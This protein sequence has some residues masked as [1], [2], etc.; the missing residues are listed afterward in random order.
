M[1][2]DYA[3]PVIIISYCRN[4]AENGNWCKSQEEIDTWLAR[5]VSYFV[6]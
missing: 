5:H 6:A 3:F 2:S 4:S 1:Y